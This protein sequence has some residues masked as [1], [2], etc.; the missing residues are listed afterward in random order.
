MQI[1]VKGTIIQLLRYRIEYVVGGTPITDYAKDKQEADA[2]VQVYGGTATK[3]DTTKDEWIDGIDVA[4]NNTP[5]DTAMEIVRMGEQGYKQHLE[6]LRQ[7]DPDVLR[8]QI[9]DLQLALADLY[10]T[11]MTG[12]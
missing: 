4:P 9:T 6:E 7:S 3:L 11:T 2:L 1:R 5:Y 12:R 10:E 8:G